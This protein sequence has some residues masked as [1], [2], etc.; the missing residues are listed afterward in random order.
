LATVSKGVC[1]A[2]RGRSPRCVGVGFVYVS[3]LLMALVACTARD[4]S[5]AK[6]EAVRRGDDF[7][8]NQQYRQAVVAYAA[9]VKIDPRDGHLQ[10]KLARAYQ[11][12]DKWTQASDTAVVASE[13]LPDDVDVQLEAGA[14]MLS[15]SRFQE[16]ADRMSRI[17]RNDPDNVSAMILWGNA[18]A[19]LTSSSWALYK[20]PDAVLDQDKY[21]IGRR[22]LRPAVTRAEDTAAEEAFRK[23]LRLQPTE[24]EAQM[25]LVNF[26]WAAG[27]PDQGERLLKNVADQNPGHASAN[28]ALGAFYLSRRR[29][30]E[31]ERYLK[32][33]AGTGIYGAAAR[34]TLA[35]YYMAA[36]RHDDVLP[37]LDSMLATDDATGDVSVRLADVEFRLGRRDAATR[38]L[39]ALL[40]RVP[41][42][43]RGRLLKAQLL[44]A[45]GQAD[46]ALTLARSAVVANPN[47]EEARV[48]L[49]RALM[50]KGD[51]DGALEQ[52][53]EAVR[54]NPRGTRSATEL[55][56][57][58]LTTGRDEL[59]LQYARQVV[60]QDPAD[61]DAALVEVAALVR[62]GDYPT[63][64]QKLK[65]LLSRH[66][67]SPDL[68][69]QLG[70]IQAARG[71]RGAV[72]TFERALA[73]N[74][75]SSDAL[76][77]FIS[78]SLES[79]NTRIAR[80]RIDQ[81][82]ARHP[83]DPA[84]LLLRARVFAAENDVPRAESTLK[85]VLE[86]D[87]VNLEA[88][89]ALVDLMTREHRATEA[90]QLLEQFVERRPRSIQAQ[91]ALAK[92][93]EQLGRKTEARARYEKILAQD[94]RAAAVGQRL[95]KL[96]VD[97]GENLDV[98][99][100][101]AIR[102]KQQLP[103]DP[104]VSDVLGWIYAKKNLPALALP[105]LRDAVRASP[106]N[107]TYRYH[108]GAAY[109]SSGD[110][111]KAQAELARALQI[112]QHFPDA[113]RA[114]AA[115]ASIPK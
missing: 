10:M 69:V 98:A 91:T 4:Q 19:R 13:L 77:G 72:A 54:R 68:I 74:P 108:L 60:R 45:V 38:R 113:A 104:A 2:T 97:Q 49:G 53:I 29:Y 66:P 33:A 36:S 73:L 99:L 105:H 59:A 50:A 16:V 84:Y 96:Y 64:D 43:A 24:I 5:V 86:I 58:A 107:A 114:Q 110:R 39:D 21:E 40:A 93:L 30:D 57:L 95:A 90:I 87:H 8:E 89:L 52:F 71:N 76:A 28:Y 47:S 103:D 81:A 80:Q 56:R 115:L 22:E 26:L 70:H 48:T 14:L 102:A 94:P 85:R 46:E 12:A 37:L 67:E 62:Q 31:A 63:A 111:Q 44:L 25:A 27:R 83:A 55:A 1:E 100:G 106:G 42:H 9:A 6:A 65:P 82:L 15:Q 61:R 34:F 41:S 109:L 3:F 88:S 75:D 32:T 78:A 18:K 35:D 7:V 23:A 101:L 112:D 79:G 17:L 20:L 92:L 51:E 11:S